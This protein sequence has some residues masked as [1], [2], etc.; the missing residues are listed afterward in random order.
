MGL[1]LNLSVMMFLQFAIW[2][3]WFVV[4]VPYLTGKGFSETEAGA[5]IGNMALGAILSTMIAGYV[6]DR[7]IASEYLMAILHLAGAG[8]LFWMAQLQDPKTDY[9]LL[10]GVSLAYALVYNPT[11]ALANSISFTH[12]PN[13]TRDFPGIRVLGT[14]GWIVVGFL[15]DFLFKTVQTTPGG[16]T[17]VTP[18]SASNGPLLLAAGLSAAL[19]VYSLFLPHTPPS[20]K[21]GDAIPFVKALGLFKDFS[22]AVFFIVSFVITIVL[23]FYY[24]EA[25][26]FL[27]QG[28]G[29][30][31]TGSTMAIG[32]LCELV[33]LPLLP[34][35]LFRMGMK[36]VLAMG[37]L[38]WGVRYALF[39]FGGPEW[40]V[41]FTLVLI[42]VALHGVCFDFFFAAG[43]IHV[44]NE[45]PRDIRASGQALFGFLTYGLGM[46][47]GN[48]LAGY[49]VD[50]FSATGTI[51]DQVVRTTDWHN[52][53]LVPSAGVLLSLLVFVVFF[54][55]RGRAPAAVP[56][57][58]PTPVERVLADPHVPTE[59][60]GI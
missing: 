13:A 37:M 40:V 1:R 6:A 22:F 5:L 43:F 58:H 47:L 60:P 59:E 44:D 53:W 34:L 57:V 2:G 19:G 52:F 7:Y 4:F 14:L 46:W 26:N 36:W 51:G 27:Q 20:G 39:A 11:L 12:I 42:G 45:A 21:A 10:F 16:T 54:R 50:Q 18:A 9:R 48:L 49:L 23:A 32:Q 17:V 41:P 56:G 29:V 8:L 15:I 31:N 28:A 35:F 55:M 33:L 24:T 3:A 30:T 25:P 38:A